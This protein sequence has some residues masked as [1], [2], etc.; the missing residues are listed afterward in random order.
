MIVFA[1]PT[2]HM[3]TI[4][5][6][7]KAEEIHISDLD[8]IRKRLAR[9]KVTWVTNVSRASGD[10]VINLL[11]KFSQQIDKQARS[12]P[13]TG[14]M[15][16]HSTGPGQLIITGDGVNL[17]FIGPLDF[18]DLATLPKDI[19]VRC[20]N[21]KRAIELGKIEVFDE[22]DKSLIRAKYNKYLKK[23]DAREKAR[24]QGLS[25]ILLDPSKKAADFV[26]SGSYDEN[27]IDMTDE[28]EDDSYESEESKFIKKYGL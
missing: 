17:T 20:H 11:E 6:D 7:G 27:A 18:K 1:D 8:A 4:V 9:K 10:D 26:S 5:N 25:S 28:Q 16:M 12:Q 14:R 23:S 19:M 13:R 3:V 21:L 2:S 24:D 15:F 22:A